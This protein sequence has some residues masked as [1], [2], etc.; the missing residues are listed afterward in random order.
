[1]LLWLLGAT[2][3]APVTGLAQEPQRGDTLT[4]RLDSL[5]ARVDSLAAALSALQHEREEVEQENA[6]DALRAAAEAA[7]AEAPAEEPQAREGEFVGR[8][9]SLQALNPEIS[10]NADV[11]ALTNSANSNEN[12][13]VPREFELSFQSPLDPFSRAKVFL[14]YHT[15]GGE[16]A[17]FGGEV[18]FAPGEEEGARFE[19]EEGY[20]EW[21]ALPG[22]FSL[23][24]GQ[25]FQQLGTL[26]RWHSHALPFQT[27]SLPHLTFIGEE[28]LGQAGISTR[29]LLPIHGAGTY[30]AT[31]EVTRS[32]NELMY[33]ESN[34]PSF[35]GQVNA[36]WQLA[37]AWDLDV[38]VAGTGGPF[39]LTP[40]EEAAPI[41]FNRYLYD[42]EASLTWRPPARALYR[43]FNLRSGVMVNAPTGLESLET[44]WGMWLWGEF[45]LGQ[46]WLVGGRYDWVQH[47]QDP[48]QTAW[49]LA[50][51]L[52]WWQSEWV[53]LRAE[54]DHLVNPDDTQNLL[55][56]QF[57][58]AMGPHKHETY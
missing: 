1:M 7:A 8:Q 46:Q 42:A 55:L 56:I 40:D 24:L 45:R 47:P 41:T 17:P 53:R 27:F 6:L 12:N 23:K 39:R 35:L 38:A 36:F 21:V 43:G 20:L 18:G 10:V 22:G 5:Q 15:P 2:A 52:T 28:N 14:S 30:E 44:A 16:L 54:F 11:L 33:G 13:F 9:R 4:Q 49:L 37:D 58:F 34:R 31:F 25:F 51:T 50:P 26:N 3:A 48:D 29:M 32:S 57:T 19:L